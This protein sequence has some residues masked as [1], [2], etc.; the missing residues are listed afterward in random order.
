MDPLGAV[1]DLTQVDQIVRWSN[2]P[3]DTDPL[4][5]ASVFG[6]ELPCFHKVP[7]FNIRPDLNEKVAFW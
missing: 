4:T 3:C 7:P 6:Q 5:A 2:V 1:S